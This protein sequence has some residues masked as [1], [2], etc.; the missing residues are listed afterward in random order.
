MK[1]STVIFISRVSLFVIYFW[2]GLLKVVGTSS[3][4][5]LVL[6]LLQKTLPFITFQQF[7]ILFGIF[8][9]VIGIFI[10]LGIFQKLTIFL[11][12]LHMFTTFLPLI[13]LTEVT[14][15]KMWVPTLEGQY[16]LKNVALVSL[17]LCVYKKK[18]F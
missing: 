8:E 15:Q 11:F 13:F 9:M 16:I 14:W 18:V 17:F 5:P 4:N 3:A 12:V 6:N 10:L 2:F 7:I 1:H